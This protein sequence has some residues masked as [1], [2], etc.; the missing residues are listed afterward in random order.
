MLMLIWVEVLLVLLELLF[1]RLKLANGTITATL[2]F[3]ESEKM[4]SMKKL[5]VLE[6]LVWLTPL[7]MLIL[8]KEFLVSLKK[9]LPRVSLTASLFYLYFLFLKIDL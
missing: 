7:S 6:L 3:N 5:K 4:F 2:D 1:K 9:V 8:E